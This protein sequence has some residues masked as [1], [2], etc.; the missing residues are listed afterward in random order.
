M[1]LTELC[2]LCSLVRVHRGGHVGACEQVGR[3]LVSQAWPYYAGAWPGHTVH[4]RLPGG[5]PFHHVLTLSFV[6]A[7]L[8][9]CG[10]CTL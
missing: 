4:R 1:L 7:L 6:A 3:S 5:F 2:S 10:H 9:R 8:A